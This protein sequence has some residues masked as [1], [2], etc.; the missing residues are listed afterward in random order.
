MRARAR[1]IDELPKGNATCGFFPL[2]NPHSSLPTPIAQSSPAGI[3]SACVPAPPPVEMGGQ[4]QNGARR[5]GFAMPRQ[6]PARPCPLCAVPADTETRRAAP[7]G[8]QAEASSVLTDDLENKKNT[9][10]RL[11]AAETN[12]F[13]ATKRRAALMTVH[14]QSKRRIL[15]RS[16][17]YDLRV[18]SAPLVRGSSRRIM[19]L[20][21]RPA[22]IRLINRRD[23]SNTVISPVFLKTKRASSTRKRVNW[24]EKPTP[25]I[26]G[27]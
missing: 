9:A 16:M 25:Q 12:P 13:S 15:L 7:A 19:T 21:F 23:S 4:C 2:W 3:T 14:G 5:Q 8:T 24:P 6:T 22:Y 26:S 1:Y 10:S 17:R 11:M 27:G 20:R 18:Q